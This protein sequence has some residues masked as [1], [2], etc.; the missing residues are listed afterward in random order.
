MLVSAFAGYAIG[1]ILTASIVSRAASRS[2]ERVDLRS[3]GSGNPGAANAIAHLGTR[4]GLAVLA[5]DIVK[6]AL[7]AAAG[8]RIGGA[9]GGY[10]AATTAVLGHCFPIWSR[11]RGGKGVA[12]SAGTPYVV[13]PAYVPI[14]MAVIAVSWVASQHAAR[15][16]YAACALFTAAAFAWSWRGWNNLWGPPPTVGLPIYALVTSL[17]IVQKFASGARRSALPT[18]IAAA[19]VSA[20]P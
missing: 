15:A 10:A 5:G 13:F 18:P 1:S 4:W 7:A 12:T 11:F 3:V 9:T 14:D 6:G 2:R 16:T 20:A 17:V 8:R 19:E